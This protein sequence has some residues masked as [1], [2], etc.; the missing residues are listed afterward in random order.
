M[1][2]FHIFNSE[3][4]ILT[5]KKPTVFFHESRNAAKY[6]YTTHW[7]IKHFHL[8]AIVTFLCRFPPFWIWLFILLDFILFYAN[9]QKEDFHYESATKLE[10]PHLRYREKNLLCLDGPGC[11]RKENKQTHLKESFTC[12][13]FLCRKTKQGEQKWWKKRRPFN[14]EILQRFAFLW[15]RSLRSSDRWLSMSERQICCFFFLCLFF[16]KDFKNYLKRL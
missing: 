3:E 2:S 10:F 13:N 4:I 1:D 15:Q 7:H 14:F 5:R 12:I 9:L 11:W 6:G 16:Q 8:M